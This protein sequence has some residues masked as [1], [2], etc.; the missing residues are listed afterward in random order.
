MP[1]EFTSTR[2]KFFKYSRQGD[3]SDALCD[4]YEGVGATVDFLISS[5]ASDIEIKGERA[6]VDRAVNDDGCGR[7]YLRSRGSPEGVRPYDEAGG[8]ED[9]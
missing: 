1:P 5:Q 4:Q 7:H 9:Q 2:S 3:R 6:E 8:M